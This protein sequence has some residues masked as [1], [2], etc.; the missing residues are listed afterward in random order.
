MGSDLRVKP[1]LAL[2]LGDPPHPKAADRG[3]REKLAVVVDQGT[4]TAPRPHSQ[5]FGQARLH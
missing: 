1:M 5:M 4:I 3:C 2:P